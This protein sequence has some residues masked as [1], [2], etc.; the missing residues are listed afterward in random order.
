MSLTYAYLRWVGAYD[1]DFVVEVIV[2]CNKVTT[3]VTTH[4]DGTKS[5]IATPVLLISGD[6][7]SYAGG[8]TYGPDDYSE[9]DGWAITLMKPL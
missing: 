9:N 5:V 4:V 8:V 2:M 7:V 6:R 1:E 3:K